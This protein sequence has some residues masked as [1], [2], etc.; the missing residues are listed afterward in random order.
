MP[1]RSE[2]PRAAGGVSEPVTTGGTVA[3]E[4]RGRPQRADARRNYDKL[5]AAAREVFAEDGVEASLEEVARRAGVGIGTLYRH[6]PARQDLFDAVYLDEVEAIC[7]WSDELDD[8]PAWDAFV[9]WTDQLVAYV[10]TKR[11]LAEALNHNSQMFQAGRAAVQESGERFLA[12]AVEAGVARP[13]LSFDDVLRLVASITM[14]DV[15][16]SGQR[17]RILRLAL[18]G[19]R[20]QP[21]GA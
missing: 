21:S 6:F 12:R 13:G 20:Y 9:S 5:V 3:S 11:A 19:L 16:D 7:R 15:V 8:L 1:R 17:D 2:E 4:S 14:V 18:D 10:S